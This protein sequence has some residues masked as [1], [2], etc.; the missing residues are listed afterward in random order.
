MFD[1]QSLIKYLLEG[2]AV[3]VAAYL[4]PKKKVDVKEIALIALTAAAVF[5]VLDQFAPLVS[6]GARQG[7][8]FGIGIQQVGFG[9]GF[10]G[11]DDNESPSLP[12]MENDNSNSET[13]GYDDYETFDATPASSSADSDASDGDI[14][15]TDPETQQFIK[16]TRRICHMT[17]GSGTAAGTCGYHPHAG[18]LEKAFFSCQPDGTKCKAVKACVQSTA[19]PP[20]CGSLSSGVTATSGQTCQLSKE[21]GPD[22]KQFCVQKATASTTAET[23]NGNDEDVADIEGFQGFS[24][25]F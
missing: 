11:F 6:A 3:A 20:T 19:T 4:I 5:A 12:G 10:E 25:V 1:L 14:D 7:A 23:F 21:L 22:N 24:K 2:L 15:L 8:G 16:N 18:P 9:H 17:P 13:E